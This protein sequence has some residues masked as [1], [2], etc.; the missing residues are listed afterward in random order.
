MAGYLMDE[1]LRSCDSYIQCQRLNLDRVA[2][3]GPWGPVLVA[4]DASLD[5][6]EAAVRDAHQQRRESAAKGDAAP[7]VAQEPD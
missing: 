1:L 7:N 2:G 3:L 4:M 5:Q 6:L